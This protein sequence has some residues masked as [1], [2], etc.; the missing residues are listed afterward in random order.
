MNTLKLWGRVTLETINIFGTYLS[1]GPTLYCLYCACGIHSI[2]INT[3]SRYY[4][5]NH[6]FEVLVEQFEGYC[7][8]VT[9]FLLANATEQD[10]VGLRLSVK[11]K[12]RLVV[13][14]LF[15]T[16]FGVSEK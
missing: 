3:A 6:M 12:P 5:N 4:H 2:I 11:I 8:V 7:I 15:E 1:I 14:L 16:Q 10:A 9:F 13:K